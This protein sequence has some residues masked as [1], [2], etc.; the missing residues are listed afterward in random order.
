[1][2]GTGNLDAGAGSSNNTDEVFIVVGGGA[3]TELVGVFF[4]DNCGLA[5]ATRPG[6]GEATFLV[7]GAITHIDGA[8]CDGVAGGV[9]LV[10]RSAAS[11]DGEHFDTVETAYRFISDHFAPFGAGP[12]H[13]TANIADLD[14]WSDFDC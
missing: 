8:T 2:I 1:V 5:L 13:D 11:D 10:E 4:Y 6:G 12:I 3:S 9:V 14:D 7:G